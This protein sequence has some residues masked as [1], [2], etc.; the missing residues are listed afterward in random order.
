MKEDSKSRASYGW[1][2]R[3]KPVPQALCFTAC[4]FDF[5]Q[6]FDDPGTVTSGNA[7]AKV[8][9]GLLVFRRLVY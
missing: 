6:E 2:H 9:V 8:F 1:R 5:W 3:F 4:L 7:F